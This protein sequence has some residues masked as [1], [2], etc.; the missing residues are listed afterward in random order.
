MYAIKQSRDFAVLNTHAFP[1]VA[2]SAYDRLVTDEGVPQADSEL[3]IEPM[4]FDNLVER[5]ADG[6]DAEAA[7]L[8]RAASDHESLAC[9][10]KRQLGG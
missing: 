9:E 10:V 4:T 8:L 6:L 3:A 7:Q 1:E 5:H 2:V